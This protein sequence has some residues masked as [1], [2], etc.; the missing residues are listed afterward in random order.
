VTVIDTV[1]DDPPFKVYVNVS[2]DD[3]GGA[4]Q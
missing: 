3:P 1:A 4:L 2:G